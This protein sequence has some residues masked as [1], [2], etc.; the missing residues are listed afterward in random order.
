[1]NFVPV[2]R[3]QVPSSSQSW[4]AVP[5]VEVPCQRTFPS[6]DWAFSRTWTN[7]VASLNLEKPDVGFSVHSVAATKSPIVFLGTG[8]HF[9][10]FEPFDARKFVQR[11]LGMWAAHRLCRIDIWWD[12]C[13]HATPIV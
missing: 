6:L 3:N 13:L 11:L 8:E 10:A 1:M 5:R 12:S 9:D 4:T 2:P 7:T